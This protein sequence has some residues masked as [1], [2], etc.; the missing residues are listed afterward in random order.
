MDIVRKIGEEEIL[1]L[2]DHKFT[3]FEKQKDFNDI[4]NKIERLEEPNRNILELHSELGKLRVENKDL[5][6]MLKDAK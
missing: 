2:L 4:D 6:S 1:V 5:V 3:L